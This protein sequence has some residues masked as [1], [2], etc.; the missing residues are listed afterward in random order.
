VK[1]KLD[2]SAGERKS[3]TTA[4]SEYFGGQIHDWNKI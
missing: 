1:Y 3:T 2:L 4:Y